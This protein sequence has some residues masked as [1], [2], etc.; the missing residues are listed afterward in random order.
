MLRDLLQDGSL[1]APFEQRV[2]TERGYWLVEADHSRGRR[3]VWGGLA[4]V[5]IAGLVLAHPAERVREFKA[6]PPSAAS[7]A[8][9]AV[10]AHLTSGSGSLSFRPN[11]C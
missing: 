9:T 1:V 4:V 6:P 2:A 7:D 10:G 11:S 5:A 3:E 8:A